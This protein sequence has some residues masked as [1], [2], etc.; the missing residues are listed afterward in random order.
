[1]K[2]RPSY[3]ILTCNCYVIEE[4]A[5]IW[6]K[7]LDI[8]NHRSLT[9]IEGEMYGERRVWYLPVV[10]LITNWKKTKYILVSFKL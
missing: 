4:Q 10:A 1:M 3:Q 2:V 7:T 5:V 9:R 8:Q 6:D